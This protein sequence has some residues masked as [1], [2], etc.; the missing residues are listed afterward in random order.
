MI[1]T[2]KMDERQWCRDYFN[3][4]ELTYSKVD[5]K[6]IEKLRDFIKWELQTYLPTTDH[7]R[8]MDMRIS[9]ELK[10]DLKFNVDGKILYGGIYIDGSYFNRRE[11]VFFEDNGRIAFCGWADGENKMPIIN[12]FIKWCDWM[13]DLK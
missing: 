11:G 5:R 6:A 9:K 4:L 2:I 10:K 3:S 12:A 1:D 7:A 13:A 8:S